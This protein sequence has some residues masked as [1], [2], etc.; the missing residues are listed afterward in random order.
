MIISASRRTDIPAFYARWFANRVREGYCLVPNPFNA[1]QVSRI[2]LTPRAVTAI[3]FWTR[4]PKPLFP[5]LP[6]LT[7]RGYPFYFLYSL[8]DYPR[9]LDAKK[10]S[11]RASLRV[12]AELS[13]MIGPERVVWRY[14]P[15]VIT[16][17]TNLDWHR[18]RFEG[19]SRALQGKTTRVAVS[20]LEPYRKIARRMEQAA[21]EGARLI[22][23]DDA[24]LERFI[25][26]IVAMARERGMTLYGCA[27]AEKYAAMGLAPGACVDPSLLR[28]VFGIETDGTK[29]SGQR[30]HCLC[31]KSRDIGMYDSC[32]FGCRY[33]YATS[34]FSRSRV[35]YASH[36]PGSPSLLGG[37]RT[38]ADDSL[39]GSLLS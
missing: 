15:I 29:D 27:Q 9:L 37:A 16:E 13:G 21:S 39:Q 7:E 14:D 24:E 20:F 1:A 22:K 31:A 19:L 38:R 23:P 3:V 5:F 33:C 32:L 34:D 25:G 26:D 4:H 28:E 2:E 17:R 35:N 8:L 6:E 10:P 18:D 11:R 12:F 30:E 36:D